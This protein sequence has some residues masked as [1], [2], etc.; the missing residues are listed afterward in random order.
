MKPWQHDGSSLEQV[1]AQHGPWSAMSI[2]LPN[3]R[4]TLPPAI[5]HR[6][7]RLVQ[8]AADLVHKPLS[9]CRVLDLACLE[10]H[11]GIEFA[12]HGAQSVCVE[13]RE[14]NL[15]K[16]AYA[17]E[18][19]GLAQRCQVVQ[20]DVRN[21]ALGTYGTF[22]II[23]CSGIL[24][25]LGADD[26][27]LLIR[28]M[29]ECCARLCIV[30]TQVAVQESHFAQVD[31]RK[32]GGF[33]YR[34]HVPN[35]TAQDKLRDLWASIDNNDSFW[36]TTN[37]LMTQFQQAGFTSC[38]EVLLPT[39]PGLTYDRRMFAAVKGQPV[40]VLSSAPTDALGHVPATLADPTDLHDYVRDYG[41]AY[42]LGKRLLPQP[43]KDA[44]KP[45]LRKLGVLKTEESPFV[46]NP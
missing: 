13:I 45:A 25:H 23:V 6:L 42:R 5:D 39:H 40:R 37:E 4:S 35:A 7:K 19:L 24:Y 41:V 26:V 20:D 9:E 21:L 16:T 12:L 8:T 2:D 27:A 18:A 36:F 28:R 10:G 14:P 17:V 15:A 1:V 32:V 31:G 29:G 43:V 46:D 34:E 38:S 44:I 3:G 33:S 22:D 11:Y 30:D